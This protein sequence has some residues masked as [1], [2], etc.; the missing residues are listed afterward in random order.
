MKR[1]ARAL[2]LYFSGAQLRAIADAPPSQYANI[3]VAEPDPSN[4][5]VSALGENLRLALKL[6][7]QDTRQGAKFRARLLQSLQLSASCSEKALSTSIENNIF[8]MHGPPEME[9]ASFAATATPRGQHSARGSAAQ[10]QSQHK[11]DQAPKSSPLTPNA[12]FRAVNV[13]APQ[14]LGPAADATTA[15]ASV[16]TV[17]DSPSKS[18]DVSLSM[19]MPGGIGLD[20]SLKSLPAAELMLNGHDGNVRNTAS[21]MA[22]DPTTSPAVAAAPFASGPGSDVRGGVRDAHAPSD[23]TAGANSLSH[24]ATMATR[25]L[26]ATAMSTTMGTAFTSPHARNRPLFLTGVDE[27]APVCQA[28][29]AAAGVDI[30]DDVGGELP[31]KE[32]WLED[33]GQTSVA[34]GEDEG[35]GRPSARPSDRPSD[36]RRASKDAALPASRST[37]A[38]PTL[39]ASRSGEVQPSFS[40]RPGG[41]RASNLAISPIAFGASN[42]SRPPASPQQ[43]GSHDVGGV[44]S[45]TSRQR[46]LA[47]SADSPRSA[48]A[49]STAPAPGPCVGA[50]G[51]AVPTWLDLKDAP[52]RDQSENRD[53]ARVRERSSLLAGG[54][55]TS[56]PSR[57]MGAVAW[58]DVQCTTSACNSPSPP[59]SPSRKAG[60]SSISPVGDR[61]SASNGG[62]AGGTD[63]PSL[64]LVS[65][66]PPRAAGRSK[67]SP[68]QRHW[69]RRASSRDEAVSVERG[70]GSAGLDSFGLGD[71]SGGLRGAGLSTTPL[72]QSARTPRPGRLAG[73]LGGGVRPSSNSRLVRDRSGCQRA[74]AAQFQGYDESGASG[75]GGG[76]YSPSPSPGRSRGQQLHALEFYAVGK[77]LGKG[78]FGKVNIGVHKLTE[79]LTAMKLCERKRIAELEAKKCLMQEVSILKRVNGHPNIIRL[80]E[81]IDTTA[82]IVLVME[83]A[84]GGDLLRYVRQRRRLVEPTA[85]D[86]FKQL[87]DGIAHI[88]DMSVVHRD[89]KLENLLLD[90]FGCLKI[91]DFGVA[92]VVK[93]PGRRLH[94]HCGTPSYIAPEIM[95]E[96]GYDGQPVDVWSAGVV[97]YAM[98]CGRVP[99]KG[100][101]LSELK[102]CIAR[103]RYQL[104][105]HMSELATSMVQGL[106][107]VDPKRRFTTEYALGH[108]WLAG[109]SNRAEVIYG[110]PLLPPSKQNEQSP[111]DDPAST[112]D[113]SEG[114]R[115]VPDD[116]VTMELLGRVAQLGFPQ[117]FVVESLTEGRLN[118]ATATFHLLAQQAIRKRAAA[119]QTTTDVDPLGE[120]LAGTG[121]PNDA[122]L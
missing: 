60:R 107:V 103:G 14:N 31:G 13:F 64:R 53:D 45:P 76:G 29:R 74:I 2:R 5:Q 78:A 6:L 43:G 97:L 23:D 111:P 122:A 65:L 35:M 120:S 100:E 51:R 20:D 91:A 63:Q 42:A 11:H 98:L 77:L 37:G 9:L 56:S 62:D 36:K 79:E 119:A 32:H 18:S 118:H 106:I 28:L 47:I 10:A 72:R 21:P 48:A 69:P 19:C 16:A 114:M 41:R 22:I 58:Q 88:H 82:H 89:I 73:T 49:S 25:S 3:P 84:T 15:R 33:T 44:A 75:G 81:V 52:S 86:F 34:H 30:D 40:L 12:S 71:A 108:P 83:F 87:L 116:P 57:S 102:R 112:A 94:E 39:S 95:M 110:G 68:R 17:P 50:C 24:A 105:S 104:P 90:S 115:I 1:A 67:E 38:T 117:A 121:G 101:N 27:S 92:V 66:S 7:G 109:V 96:M 46:N 26:A 99:F 55:V 80:F 113:M 70:G 61:N 85:R 93:P 54:R 59:I 4:P 8:G